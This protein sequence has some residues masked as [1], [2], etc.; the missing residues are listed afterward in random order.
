MPFDTQIADLRGES[1]AFSLLGAL[2]E[3]IPCQDTLDALR[4]EA[5]FESIPIGDGVQSVEE[6][7][8]ALA[9]VVEAGVNAGEVADEHLRLFD[10]LPAPLAPLWESGYFNDRGLAFQDQMMDVRARFRR[11]GLQ[12]AMKNREPDDSLG[13]ELQ[14]LA[15]LA[16][17]AADAL[18]HGDQDKAA[19][20]IE[21]H[22]EFLSEHTL[23]W[24]GAWADLV[25]RHARNPFYPALAT[26]VEALVSEVAVRF[27]CEAAHRPL[28][29]A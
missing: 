5:V 7:L 29:A 13:L 8:A 14:F 2:L 1:I 26:L 27:S 20:L 24:V 6:S 3:G 9:S 22:N 18:S 21:E 11:Q 10:G 15:L 16:D 12:S 19:R 4:R 23:C 28:R 25:R 17:R